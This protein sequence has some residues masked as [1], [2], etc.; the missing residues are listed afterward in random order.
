MKQNVPPQGIPVMMAPPQAPA[1]SDTQLLI[2]AASIIRT[3][4]ESN[5]L[6]VTAA[7]EIMGIVAEAEFVHRA[8]HAPIP[9]RTDFNFAKECFYC[10]HAQRNKEL[11]DLLTPKVES[12]FS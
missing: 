12:P 10:Q 5:A 9:G 2:L 6:S 7:N 3:K 4:I 8:K 11:R 1:L